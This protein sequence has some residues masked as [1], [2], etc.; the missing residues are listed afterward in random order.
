MIIKHV[1]LIVLHELLVQLFDYMK[2]TIISICTSDGN[3]PGVTYNKCH[4]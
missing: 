1:K 4:D 3:A 2:Y